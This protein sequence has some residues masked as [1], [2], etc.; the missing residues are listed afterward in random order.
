MKG[1]TV[2][3]LEI[4]L[5]PLAASGGELCSSKIKIWRPPEGLMKMPMKRRSTAVQ[6]QPSTCT[7]AN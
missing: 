7:C 6:A 1:E 4:F 5:Q 3:Q 2:C